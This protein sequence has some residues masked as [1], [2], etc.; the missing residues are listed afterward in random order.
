MHLDHFDHAVLE[1]VCGRDLRGGG[2]YA[3]LRLVVLERPRYGQRAFV[4]EGALAFGFQRSQAI[5]GG[6]PPGGLCGCG[7]R[8]DEH[9]Q[10]SDQ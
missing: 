4:V 6:C 8:R 3:Q 5:D 9:G 7:S 2:R 1:G 10:E